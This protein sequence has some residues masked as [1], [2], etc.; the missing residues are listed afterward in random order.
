MKGVGPHRQLAGGAGSLRTLGASADALLRAHRG[1]RWA[2]CF[3]ER[4]GSPRLA[5]PCRPGARPCLLEGWREGK[6]G[7]SK[8]S[9]LRLQEPG[10]PS[11]SRIRERPSGRKMSAEEK[12]WLGAHAHLSSRRQAW[13]GHSEGPRERCGLFSS[14]ITSLLSPCDFLLGR[15]GRRAFLTQNL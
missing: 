1:G 15:V 5:S 13:P 7:G 12:L 6:I 3:S 2:S 10:G 4:Q 9:R 14:L 11:T 8:F